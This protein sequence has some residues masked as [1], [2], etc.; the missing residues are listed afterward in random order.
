MNITL[1][2]CLLICHY[3]ADFQWT[4]PAMIAAKSKGRPFMPILNHAAVHGTLI[5]L[6]LC[7][8]GLPWLTIVLLAFTELATHFLI[9]LT[10]GQI[11]AHYPALSDNTKK[12]YWQ[13]FGFDQMLHILVIISIW[14]VATEV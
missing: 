8:F 11:T 12:P 7:A 9:D 3:L 2:I 5:L 6:C 14:Y 13:L 4:T 10:K 1:L